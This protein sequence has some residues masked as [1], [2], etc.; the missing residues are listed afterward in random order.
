MLQQHLKQNKDS[1]T[2]RWIDQ[3]I[4]TYGP[5]M[6]RFLKQ[7]KDQFA[8]PVRNTIVT[9]L[10]DILEGILNSK[11]ID[12]LYPELEEIVKLRAVQDFSPSSALSFL[13][14]LKNI[15]RDEVNSTDQIEITSTE[16]QVM[17]D[18]IDT[19]LKM[20]FDIYSNR[21]FLGFFNNYAFF[22]FCS[23]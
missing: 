13:F 14:S 1:I 6:V 8:N 19:L 12:E 20:A 10:K 7:E 17:D 5:E 22:I 4:N 21:F 9:S 15:I 16:M 11:N 18:K 23:R 2:A 3:T